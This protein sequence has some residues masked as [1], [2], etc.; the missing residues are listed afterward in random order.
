MYW[1]KNNI[2]EM[3]IGFKPL[4]DYGKTDEAKQIII[5]ELNYILPNGPYKAVEYMRNI[6]GEESFSKFQKVISKAIRIMESGI[7]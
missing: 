3:K 4:D 5:D 7:K 2:P 1:H 6:M